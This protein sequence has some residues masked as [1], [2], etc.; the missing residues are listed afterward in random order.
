MADPIVIPGERLGSTE[1]YDA[2]PGSYSRQGYIYASLVG[3]KKI[4]EKNADGGSRATI[5]VHS[6]DE[7]KQ[8]VPEKGRKSIC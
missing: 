4:V 5:F 8:F 2:G 7:P 6:G 3:V 1:E